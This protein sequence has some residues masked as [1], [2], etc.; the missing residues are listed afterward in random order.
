VPAPGSAQTIV[1]RLPVEGLK[2]K[3][4]GASGFQKHCDKQAAFDLVTRQ[5][6]A[7]WQLVGNGTPTK[8][9]N[10]HIFEF[11]SR[12]DNTFCIGGGQGAA[13]A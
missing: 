1:V 9:R 11:I 2:F 6:E 4:K 7:V 3:A 12:R 10:R 5:M 13:S 8:G